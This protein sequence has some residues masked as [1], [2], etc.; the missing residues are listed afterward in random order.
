MSEEDV[1]RAHNADFNFDSPDSLDLDEAY[2]KLMQLINYE[3]IDLPI[4]DFSTHSRKVNQ[5]D[6]VKCQPL[7]IFEGILALHDKRFRDLMDLKIFVKTDD[8]IRLARRI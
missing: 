7:I 5:F 2:E 4:Y 6:H 1:A 8:D 3:D